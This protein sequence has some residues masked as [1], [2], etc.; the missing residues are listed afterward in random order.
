MMIEQNLVE[1]TWKKIFLHE[2]L[3]QKIV[4]EYYIICKIT[5]DMFKLFSKLFSKFYY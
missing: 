5:M 2:F 4:I 3:Y 1:K